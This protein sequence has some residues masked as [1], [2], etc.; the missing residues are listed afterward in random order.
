VILLSSLHDYHTPSWQV[1]K[2]AAK[3]RENNIGKSEVLLLT[4]MNSG[5]MGNT[6]GKEWIRLYSQIY[7]FVKGNLF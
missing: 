2:F 3:L 5:H 4:D 6:T 7:S 1:S